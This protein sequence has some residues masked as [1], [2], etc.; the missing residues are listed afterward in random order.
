MTAQMCEDLEIFLLIICQTK[1]LTLPFAG[2]RGVLGVNESSGTTGNSPCIMRLQGCT[3]CRIRMQ[4]IRNDW[5]F[6]E[7]NCPS[8]Y[9]R[10]QYSLKECIPGYVCN[11]IKFRLLLP[12]LGNRVSIQMT[13]PTF[14]LILK[15]IQ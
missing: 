3:Q 10:R 13:F 12:S 14:Y 8:L 11:V 6:P 1:Y 15:I 5:H 7:T 4:P 2:D 9:M